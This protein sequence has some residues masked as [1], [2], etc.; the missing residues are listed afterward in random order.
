MFDPAKEFLE[1]VTLRRFVED[2]EASPKLTGVGESG[3]VEEAQSRRPQPVGQSPVSAGRA[4]RKV[5]DR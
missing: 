5:G 1:G 3:G 2:A 4:G